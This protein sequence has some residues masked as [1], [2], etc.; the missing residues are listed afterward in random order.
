MVSNKTIIRHYPTLLDTIN[1]YYPT[2][3]ATIKHHL[4]S[5]DTIRHLMC[6]GGAGM[7]ST[8]PSSGHEH[9]AQRTAVDDILDDDC[10]DRKVNG[11][12]CY[13]HCIA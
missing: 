5:S 2:P 1:R 10:D 3:S 12:D 8:K 7:V 11:D 13:M 9:L 6:G 4:T